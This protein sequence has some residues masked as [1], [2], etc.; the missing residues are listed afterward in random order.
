MSAALNSGQINVVPFPGSEVGSSLVEMVGSVVITCAISNIRLNVTARAETSGQAR[1]ALVNSTARM[2]LS[3]SATCGAETSANALSRLKFVPDAET[4]KAS[5][6]PVGA[7]VRISSAAT[8]SG[9]AQV[10]IATI[11][12]VARS[13][14]TTASGLGAATSAKYVYASASASARADALV[15]ALRKVLFSASGRGEVTISA[16]PALA[17]RIGAPGQ[18]SGLGVATA[19][20]SI[21]SSASTLGRATGLASIFFA[22]QAFPDLLR[23]EAVAPSVFATRNISFSASTIAIASGSSGIQISHRPSAY[24]EA[25]AIA[26][27]AAAD[28]AVAAPAPEERQM[29][30]PALDRRMEVAP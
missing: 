9:Q 16:M 17:H 25:M 13:A 2:Q 20:R 21:P 15:S 8:T 7:F 23:A 19:R 28:Y 14:S 5:V 30:V 10:S 18:A 22:R 11:K 3:A 27:S 6:Q 12:R 24:T 4:A 29:F 1:S 26:L